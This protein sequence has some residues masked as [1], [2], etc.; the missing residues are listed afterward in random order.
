ME[1][2]ERRIVGFID[3]LG[4]KDMINRYD[5]GNEPELLNDLKEVINT[6]GN[7]LKRELPIPS[8]VNLKNWKDFLEVK[9][10]S[11]C[12][13]I[14][15]P[16]DHPH[17]AFN[18]NVKLYYQYISGFQILLME[19]GYFFRGGITIGS[20]Y[21]DDNLIFSGGLVEAYDLESKIAKMPRVIVSESFL[22]EIHDQKCYSAICMLLIDNDITFVNP[23]NHNLIDSDLVD[24]MMEEY[25][26][27]V[28]IQGHI[29]K[30]FREMDEEGKTTTLDNVL[31]KVEIELSR[32]GLPEN[33]YEK[34]N[35][36]RDFLNYEKGIET[37]IKF[38]TFK[39]NGA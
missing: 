30:S 12:F 5:S 7:F 18:E 26:K 27:E 38:K 3:I 37:E 36:L 21:S 16:F 24:K 15:V 25:I 34:Y 13:C 9:V 2:T 33:V 35:W 29:D 11:D 19:K 10:F 14:S 6:A 8:N 20:Y 4:F 17:F 28:G 22:K 39:I 1:T 31:S 23:F 32:N